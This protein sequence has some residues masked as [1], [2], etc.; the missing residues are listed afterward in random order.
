VFIDLS[1]T[2]TVVVSRGFYVIRVFLMLS[3]IFFDH[4]FSATCTEG[5]EDVHRSFPASHGAHGLGTAASH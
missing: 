4:D 3:L 5:L 2:L 1:L